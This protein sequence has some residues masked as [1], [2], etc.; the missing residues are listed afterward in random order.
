MSLPSGKFTKEQVMRGGRGMKMIAK[1][2][3]MNPHPD[4]REARRLRKRK[5][6]KLNRK[7]K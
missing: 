3:G 5:Q 6:A 1:Q 7:N 2:L 4:S